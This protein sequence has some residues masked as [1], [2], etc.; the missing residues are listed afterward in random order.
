MSS[1]KPNTGKTNQFIMKSQNE[2]LKDNTNQNEA[3]QTSHEKEMVFRLLS[4]L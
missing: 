2:A 1:Y 3:K 4:K